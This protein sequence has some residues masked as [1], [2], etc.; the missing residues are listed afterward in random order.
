MERSAVK[1][2]MY[3]VVS[4]MCIKQEVRQG[5]VASPHLFA[6]YTDK[7]MRTIDEL[8]GFQIGVKLSIM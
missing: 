3:T 5:C 7:I 6:L 2:R 8:D 1:Q 4:V